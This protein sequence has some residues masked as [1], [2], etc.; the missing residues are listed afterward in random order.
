MLLFHSL[1]SV[2]KAAHLTLL[3]FAMILSDAD[4]VVG[5]IQWM[6]INCKWLSHDFVQEL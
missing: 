5:A 6:R 3:D 1:S 4:G 2:R